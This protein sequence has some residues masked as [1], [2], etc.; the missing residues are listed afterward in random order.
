MRI[1][2]EESELE[3]WKARDDGRFYHFKTYPIC[4]W[5]GDV[6][7]KTRLGDKQAPEGFYR[8]SNTQMNPN[9]QLLPRLQSRLSRTPTTAL[10]SA[11]A[12]R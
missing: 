12:T 3:V 10:G 6:G 2:K 7:P 1:F 5:S 4:N 11:P 9:S 8:V